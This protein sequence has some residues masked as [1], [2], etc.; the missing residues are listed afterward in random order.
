M[1]LKHLLS[2][3]LA[4]FIGIANAQT[5]AKVTANVTTA[6]DT[7]PPYLKHPE[8]P[9]FKIQLMDSVSSLNTFNI[10]PG[11]K[12]VLMLFSPDCE[13]CQHM[14]DSMKNHLEELKSA[15]IYMFSFMELKD[16]KKFAEKYKLNKEK[17][18]TFGKDTDF[19]FAGFYRLTSVPGIAVYDEKKKFVKL[20]NG[21]AK[22]TDIVSAVNNK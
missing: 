6:A 14:A 11:K 19:F 18:I 17:N 9:A 13:H 5:Q 22:I 4:G 8:M 21:G 16:I 12:T 7:M 20:F 10:K 1:K 15:N 3:L 2:I